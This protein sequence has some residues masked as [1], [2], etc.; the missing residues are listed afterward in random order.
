MDLM[1]A[2]HVLLCLERRIGLQTTNHT[3]VAQ[4]AQ[5]SANLEAKA[6]PHVAVE[7]SNCSRNLVVQVH[8]SNH[9]LKN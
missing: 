7:V 4:L 3:S 8:A 1:I 5:R 9:K 6:S 2:M